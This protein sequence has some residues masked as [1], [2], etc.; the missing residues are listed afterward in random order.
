MDMSK[1]IK[2]GDKIIIR[3]EEEGDI[4]AKCTG[5]THNNLVHY[6]YE[7]DGCPVAGF[8]GSLWVEKVI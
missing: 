3:T 1:Q 4:H 5:V 7:K 8:V 6:M 2:E